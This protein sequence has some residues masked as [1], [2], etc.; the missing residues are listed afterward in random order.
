VLTTKL[1]MKKDPALDE[2]PKDKFLFQLIAVAADEQLDS[3]A[4]VFSLIDGLLSSPYAKNFVQ[5]KKV[6]ITFLPPD[7]PTTTPAWY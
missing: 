1:P 7:D 5:D 6:P 3:F 4:L 2:N